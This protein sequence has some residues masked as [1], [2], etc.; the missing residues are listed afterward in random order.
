MVEGGIPRGDCRQMSATVGLFTFWPDS[1][2]SAVSDCRLMQKTALERATE[3]AQI[4]RF[5]LNSEWQ[6]VGGVDLPPKPKGMWRRS[7][8]RRCE[9]IREAD[10]A[11]EHQSD[12]AYSAPTASLGLPRAPTAPATA[13]TP[14]LSST[15]SER[16]RD[17]AMPEQTLF[18]KTVGQSLPEVPN[19]AAS[20]RGCFC[21]IH[22]FVSR[23]PSWEG[24]MKRQI[25]LGGIVAVGALSLADAAYQ[26]SGTQEPKR[27]T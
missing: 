14:A 20:T 12:L 19:E 6:P 13:V 18:S 9:E 11:K 25:V 8:L 27:T 3:R 4:L 5:Q 1:I 21:V 7:Y 24:V 2:D 16:I 26:Q 15:G 22:P 17:E 10:V 23:S